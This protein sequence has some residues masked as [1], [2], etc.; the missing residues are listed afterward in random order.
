VIEAL[1]D[2]YLELNKLHAA[3]GEKCHMLAMSIHFIERLIKQE[4][5]K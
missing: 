3:P 4:M 1:L 2:T 5:K